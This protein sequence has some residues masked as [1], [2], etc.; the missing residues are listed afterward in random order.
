MSAPAFAGDLPLVEAQGLLAW[1]QGIHGGWGPG[2]G[3]RVAIPITQTRTFEKVP[4][5]IAF[6]FGAGW[7]H[8]ECPFGKTGADCPDANAI[9]VPLGL[10]W[11]FQ[12]HRRFSVFLEPG[13]GA[14]VSF[15]REACPMGAVCQR[16][17]HVGLRPLVSLGAIVH[18]GPLA[19]VAR[20]GFPTFSLGLGL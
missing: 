5:Q 18:L 20:A 15:F 16:F 12:L 13:L 1:D 7:L 8:F 6:S 4:D 10:A 14:F 2:A 17:D 19:I 3:A 11:S 9:W